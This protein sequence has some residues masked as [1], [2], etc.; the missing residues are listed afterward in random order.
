[1]AIST[2]TNRTV[3]VGDGS[4]ASFNFQYEFHSQSDLNVYI[5]N[6]S[7]PGVLSTKTLNTDYVISGT[8]D[9]QNRYRNG[10]NVI[11][12]SSPSSTDQITIVRNVQPSQPFDLKFSQVIPNAELVKALDRLA[13]L[14]QRF[15]DVNDTRILRVKDA[16]P[17]TFNGHLPNQLVKGAALIIGSSG[18]TIEMGVVAQT[19]SSATSYFGILPVPNGGT[20]LDFS[21]L[22]GL[23]YSPGNNSTFSN[24]NNGT[25][26]QVMTSNGSSAPSFQSFSAAAVNSGIISVSNGGTGTGT[27]YIQYGVVF[28]SSATQ[29]ATTPAGGLDTTLMGNGAAAP[30]YRALP[31]NSN[32]S[33]TNILAQSHGGTNSASSWALAALIYQE[34]ATSLGQIPSA[35]SGTVLT[36]NGSSAPSFQTPVAANSYAVRP[37]QFNSGLL[38]AQTTDSVVLLRGSSFSFALFDAT[39]NAGKVL[40]LVHA[41]SSYVQSYTIQ[42]QTSQSLV[43]YVMYSNKE[44]LRIIATEGVWNIMEHQAITGWE[45]VGDI[46]VSA[47]T[48]APVPRSSAQ[49]ATNN[50]YVMRNANYADIRYEYYSAIAGTSGSGFYKLR[51]PSILPSVN[52]SIIMTSSSQ[53]NGQWGVALIGRGAGGV[54]ASTVFDFFPQMIDGNFVYCLLDQMS[55]ASAGW[56]ANGS[57]N[58]FGAA[59][60]GFGLTIRVPI[61]G[62]NP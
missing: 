60:M 28:A 4:S 26:G 50:V 17:L 42:A 37:V 21:L 62:W 54:D 39:A 23:I 48:T 27:S 29:M 7:R 58:A 13:L 3:Y 56:W 6:S 15:K 12:N 19:A 34:S 31:L 44:R 45:R 22:Q 8:A 61:L 33:V 18:Q 2:T 46:E 47:V 24:I 36:A 38:T 10:A 59:N 20:G 52:S 9:A 49:G 1:M 16:Y 35:A 11:F 30:S 25:P 57:T 40:E 51:I 53:V 14:E 55:G 41:G 43:N 32:S 5:W